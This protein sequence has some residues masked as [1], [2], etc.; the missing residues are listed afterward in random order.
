MES[1]MNGMENFH[2]LG[3]QPNFEMYMRDN[4][5]QTIGKLG[6][7]GFGKNE[8]CSPE[9]AYLRWKDMPKMSKHRG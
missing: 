9:F 8:Q 7:A 4:N 3:L 1:F 5:R 2:P 6:F